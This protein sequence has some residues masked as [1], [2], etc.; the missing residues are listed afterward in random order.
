MSTQ[1][2]PTE[3]DSFE[4]VA[5]IGPG[6]VLSFSNRYKWLFLAAIVIGAMLGGALALVQTP[7]YRSE[8]VLQPREASSA[9]ELAALTGLGGLTG[10]L[11]LTGG[12]TDARLKVLAVLE[13]RAFNQAFIERHGL[14]PELFHRK[15]DAQRNDWRDDVDDPPTIRDA[16]RL[17][18]RDV[19]QILEDRERGLIT[20]R[21]DWRDRHLAT[22]WANLLAADVDNLLRSLEIEEA[23]KNLGYLQAQLATN[24][25][26]EVRQSIFNLI[27]TEI[28][29]RMVA[30][31]RERFLLKVIDPA[32]IADDDEHVRPRPALMIVL[33]ATVGLFIA[34][35]AALVHASR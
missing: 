1:T 14:L 5:T 6:S 28:K 20:I 24:P 15:W 10:A 32:T 11:G 2:R 9:P 18:D 35:G 12:G 34:T 7:I 3:P 17:F 27:E 26:I 21:I 23:E 16:Y 22:T 29:R 4:R 30:E 25:E 8:V 31:S 19:R 33:G 13:S